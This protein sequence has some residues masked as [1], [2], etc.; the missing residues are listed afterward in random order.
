MNFSIGAKV[1]INKCDACPNVVGKTVT[2]KCVL[3]DG[4]ELNYGRGRPQNNRPVRISKDDV[5]LVETE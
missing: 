1:K 4:L 2:V 3:D 5:S